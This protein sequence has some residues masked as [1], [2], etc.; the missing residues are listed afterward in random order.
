M[1]LSPSR[2]PWL[3][4]TGIQLASGK[5]LQFA[6]WKFT[7]FNGKIH[8]FDWAIFNSDVKLPEGSLE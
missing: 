2:D 8:Y 7:M 5:R 1:G 4:S 3:G 6:N